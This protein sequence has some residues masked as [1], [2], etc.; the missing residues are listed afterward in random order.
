MASELGRPGKMYDLVEDAMYTRQCNHFSN[1]ILD[2]EDLVNTQEDS[3]RNETNSKISSN[4]MEKA[5]RE[6]HRM[7]S[8]QA[9][10]LLSMAAKGKKEPKK[11]S[12]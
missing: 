10:G 2:K 9:S 8:E 12:C 5:V 11:P 7:L 4:E 3:S 6:E 1:Y